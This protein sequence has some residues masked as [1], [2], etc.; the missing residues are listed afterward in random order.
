MLRIKI[1]LSRLYH[2]V[3][4]LLN[5]RL[6]S[7]I[8]VRNAGETVDYIKKNRVSVSRYGDGELDMVF[9]YVYGISS[10]SGFQNYDEKLGERLTSILGQNNSYP[11][12][13]HIVCLPACAFSYGCNHFIAST[14][15]IWE[16]YSN[17]HLRQLI[18]ILDKDRTYYETNFT[19][20]YLS[21]KNKDKCPMSLENIKSIW[22]GQEVVI[23]EGTMTRSGVGNDLYDNALSVKRVLCPATNAFGKYDEILSTITSAVKKAQDKLILL[24]L[25]MTATVLAYDLSKLGYWAIDIG[26]LDIEYEWM[27]R[28]AKEK[29]AIPGKF[30]NEASGGKLVDDSSDPNYLSSI[31]ARIE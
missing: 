18:S 6:R 20:F 15:H 13:K 23:V 3:R 24:S 25:G 10:T 30:T 14:R 29:I 4:F 17:L 22:E 12:P 11:P 16:A 31:I 19:R 26:H 21:H 28:K 2:H 8:D 9:H 1:F 27:L 7:R 5:K